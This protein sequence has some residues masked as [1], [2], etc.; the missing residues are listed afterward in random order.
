MD[1]LAAVGDPELREALRFVRAQRHPVSA[2]ELADDQAVHR[3]V[4]RARLE[5]LAKA[6]LLVSRFERRTGRTGPGAGRPAKV[7]SPAPETTAIEFPER[8]YAE[9]VAL[10]ADTLP[11]RGRKRRLRELG[12]EL[13]RPLA[14]RAKLAPTRDLRRG[15]ERV[16]D[17]LGRLG[18]QASVEE[19]RDD[20]IVISTPTCPLRPLVVAR[21]ELAEVDRGMWCGLIEAAVE[22]VQ[23]AGVCCET[24]D[25]LDDH[26]SC[27]VV[28]TLGQKRSRR[29]GTTSAQN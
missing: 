16:C 19:V 10:L 22:G 9:L 25:C 4:A 1:A 29:R 18:F 12:I 17:A 24:R 5:R 7:Y 21:P 15:V 11:E 20:T 6:G 14:R 8:H 28:A 3:N 26:A 27:R 13:A 2:D 23:A